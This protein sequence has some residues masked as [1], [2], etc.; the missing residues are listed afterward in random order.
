MAFREPEK[1]L[2]IVEVYRVTSRTV[3]VSNVPLV[4]RDPNRRGVG[5][6]KPFLPSNRYTSEA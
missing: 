2:P 5:E 6:S 1:L 4:D 3:V